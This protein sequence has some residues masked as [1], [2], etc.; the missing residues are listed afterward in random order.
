MFIISV[1]ANDTFVPANARATEMVRPVCWYSDDG[2]WK[3]HHCHLDIGH[4]GPHQD[5]CCVH[6]LV[7]WTGGI[8]PD[9]AVVETITV[10]RLT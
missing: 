2:T 6:G 3:G 8:A 4:N 1:P 7:E 5:D 10:T 9:A